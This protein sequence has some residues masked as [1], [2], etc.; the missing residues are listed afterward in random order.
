[1]LTPDEIKAL[2]CVLGGMVLAGLLA[3]WIIWTE[4]RRNRRG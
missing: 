4:N 1:M 3:A 2:S